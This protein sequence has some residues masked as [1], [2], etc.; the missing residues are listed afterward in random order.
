MAQTLKILMILHMPWHRDLGGSRVQLELADE[1][2]AM[3]HEVQKFDYNDAF[4]EENSSFLQRLTRPSFA[5]KAKAFVQANA[6]RFDIIDAHQGNLPFSKQEL[7]IKGLLVARSV[8][9][10]AF[11][12]EFAKQEKIKWPPK[13]KKTLIGNWLRS[14]LSRKEI[15]DCLPSLQNCDVINVPNQDE[16]AYVRDVLG[17]GEKCFV[18]PFGLS[19]KRQ[20]AFAQAVQP[21]AV[22]LASKQVVFIGT[23]GARKGARDFAEIMMRTKAKVPDARFLFLGTA[24]SSEAI[25]ADLDMPACDW[26]EIVPRFAGEELPKLLSKATVGAFPSYIEG[27]GF[28]VLEKL[29]CGLPTVAYNVPGPREMLHHFDDD[30]MVTAGDSEQ[31][32]NQIIKLLTLDEVSYSQLSQQCIEVARIFSWSQIAKDTLDVYRKFLGV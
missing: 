3:G 26:I 16:Q 20:Q 25:F 7:G 21:A 11:Y 31:F 24:F 2:R 19:P 9:L 6:H 5:S 23:W 1:F 17:M 15:S 10:Y 28:A 14:W 8:G 4:P 13:R 32:S 30:L 29:A 18:F 22:R 27:F 12:E